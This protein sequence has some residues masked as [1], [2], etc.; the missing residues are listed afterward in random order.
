MRR[1]QQHLN[2]WQADV[3][4]IIVIPGKW[5]EQQPSQQWPLHTSPRSKS[6]RKLVS[7]LHDS[8]QYQQVAQL[9]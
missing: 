8:S 6:W 4:D 3:F 5:Q 2:A 9:A 7:H 1:G